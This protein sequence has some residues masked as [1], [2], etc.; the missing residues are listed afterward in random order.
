MVVQVTVEARDL[1]KLRARLKA[2]GEKGLTREL[3][4][5]LKAATEPVMQAQRAAARALPAH[6]NKH[7]GLRTT[8]A[9]NVKARVRSSTRRLGVSTTTTVPGTKRL[10]KH[11]NQKSWRHPVY[12]N[13]NAWVSQSLDPDWFYKAGL[14]KRAEAREL[15]RRAIAN[16][17]RQIANK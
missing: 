13:R 2:A 11:T 1:A 8:L 17:A 16:V 10:A 15:V 7:T 6:G 9:A 12:G 3:N 4:R 5:Q 14:S